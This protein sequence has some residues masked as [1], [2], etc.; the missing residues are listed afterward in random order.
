[1]AYMKKIAMIVVIVACLVSLGLVWKVDD[2]K[3]ANLANIAELDGKLKQTTATLDTTTKD[4]AKTKTDR[5]QLQAKLTD[6]EDKLTASI[7]AKKKAVA[8]LEAKVT[9]ADKRATDATTKMTEV[10]SAMQKIKDALGI[11]DVIDPE[12]IRKH[13]T[14]QADENKLLGEEI[15][16]LN[17][18]ISEQD[19]LLLTPEGVR[20]KVA[21]VE[22]KWGFLVLDVGSAD[23]VHKATE[24]LIYRD[25]TLVGKA[26]ITYVGPDTSIAQMIP[27]Y[28]KGVARVGDLAIH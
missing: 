17:N 5:D 20:G 2:M 11:V 15:A 6:T 28:R 25:S 13:A 10:V 4:L 24:F 1:M 26:L 7:E 9:D 14:A 8:E 3:K 23:K 18:R 22:D 27:E 16:K 12:E 21:M 19:K